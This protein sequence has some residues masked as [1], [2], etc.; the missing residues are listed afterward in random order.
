MNG[1]GFCCDDSK[2]LKSFA[3]SANDNPELFQYYYHS[4][5]LGSSSLITNLDGEVVQHIEYVPFGEVFIEERNNTWNTPYLFNAKELDEETGLYYYGARYYDPRTSIWLSTDPLQEKYPNISTYA[6]CIQNPVKYVDPNGMDWYQHAESGGTFWQEGNAGH[7]DR[8]GLRYNNIGAAYV[9]ITGNMSVSFMQD[10]VLSVNFLDESTSGGDR[11]G[12]QLSQGEKS[13]FDKWRDNAPI[14]YSIINDAYVTLQPLTFELITGGGRVNEFT[15]G[16]A[17]VNLDGTTNYKGIDSATRT[18]AL[19]FSFC[20]GGASSS[21]ATAA[22]GGMSDLQLL[23]KA[24]Q[25]AEVAIGGS[26]GVAGTLK[27]TYAKNLLGRYQSIYGD[28]GLS[29]GS[30]YFNGPAGKGFLDVVNHNTKMIYDFKFG[31]AFMSN[32]QYLKYSNS[33]PGYGIQ[34]IKP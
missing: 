8:D 17:L 33:F 4:D 31:N 23:T 2:T 30:N 11:F 22:K 27:H 15:G 12:S 26:G 32:S 3:A 1:Q 19:L 16:H 29:V 25:K 14:T 5:H 28:R 9:D 6:Y 34:I 13:F 24:A 18:M 20:G 21:T 10:Q 7:V